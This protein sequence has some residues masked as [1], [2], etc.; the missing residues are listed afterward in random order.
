MACP[1]QAQTVSHGPGTMRDAEQQP[2]IHCQ[3]ACKLLR[4]SRACKGT[5]CSTDMNWLHGTPLHAKAPPCVGHR[6]QRGPTDT[7]PR[8]CE[9]RAPMEPQSPL[10][11]RLL[12]HDGHMLE[13]R[14]VQHPSRAHQQGARGRSLHEHRPRARLSRSPMPRQILPPDGNTDHLASGD[15]R[16]SSLMRALRAAAEAQPDPSAVPAQ[17]MA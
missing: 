2:Y 12:E 16:H 1:R 15:S 9:C 5:P 10:C 13:T 14:H 3:T 8:I 7:P 11:C 6:T 4:R 17:R